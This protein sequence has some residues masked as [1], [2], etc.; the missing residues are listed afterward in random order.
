MIPTYWFTYERTSD[1]VVLRLLSPRRLVTCPQLAVAAAYIDPDGLARAAEESIIRNNIR[2][3]VCPD[4]P[5]KSMPVYHRGGTLK[6]TGEKMAVYTGSLMT[7]EQMADLAPKF[8]ARKLTVKWFEGCAPSDAKQ[9]MTMDE[10]FDAV[11]NMDPT[12]PLHEG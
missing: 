12:G 11:K 7:H 9:G 4:G 3:T 8:P 2:S 5:P 1:E 6:D 10:V